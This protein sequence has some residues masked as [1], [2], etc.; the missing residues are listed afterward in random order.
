M[1][2]M[3][4]SE[5]LR[6]NAIMNGWIAVAALVVFQLLDHDLRVLPRE[7][8]R[9]GFA[10]ALHAMAHAALLDARSSRRARR[11]RSSPE[12]AIADA[13]TTLV[14]AGP[15]LSAAAPAP[16]L[17]GQSRRP[18]DAGPEAAGTVIALHRG[19]HDESH[20]ERQHGED[21]E[22]HDAPSE[23]RVAPRIEALVV[24]HGPPMLIAGTD[25]SLSSASCAIG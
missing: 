10:H 1:S 24:H 8:G 5:R 6:A 4:R 14:D 9:V 22:R 18:A 11:R 12:R 25:V 3:S 19:Q 17:R 15:A 13:R 7:I 21:D 23:P 2:A 20:Q 16:Q